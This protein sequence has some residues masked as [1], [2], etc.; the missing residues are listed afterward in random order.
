MYNSWFQAGLYRPMFGLYDPNH[1]SVANLISGFDQEV[2]FKAFAFGTAPNVPF[3]N[4]HLISSVKDSELGTDKFGTGR[5]I[6]Q[7]GVN[8]NAGLRFVTYSANVKA[9]YWKTKT[10]ESYEADEPEKEM[11]SITAGGKFGRFISNAEILRWS[12]TDGTGENAGNVYTIDTKYRIWRELYA[13]LLFSQSNTFASRL[14]TLN[15]VAGNTT[16]ITFGFK[17]YIYSGIKAE[18]LVTNRTGKS[19]ETQGFIP[20]FEEK[21]TGAMAQFHFY[22]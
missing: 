1:N 3:A 10:H 5:S 4:I 17:G 7:D 2:L 14:G 20:P 12:I 22:F 11:Y 16:D 13:S 19:T 18:V 21:S 8:I 15:G 9:S 6:G